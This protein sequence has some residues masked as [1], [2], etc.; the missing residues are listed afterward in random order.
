MKQF[1]IAHVF[2][3]RTRD[4]A[5]LSAGDLHGE[6]TRLM[7]ALLDL[8][9]I[10]DDTSDATT[11]SDSTQGTITAELLV[12]ADGEVDALEKCLTV[13]RTAIHTIG[14]NTPGWPG[15]PVGV[16][17]RPSYQPGSVQLLPV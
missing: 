8:E 5:R 6:G 12:W 13:L 17:Q 1:H 7:D 11:S 4:G 14:G 2:A 15:Q 3:V 16:S 9:Q 10:N